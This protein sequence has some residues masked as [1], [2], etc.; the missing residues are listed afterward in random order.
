MTHST[1]EIGSITIPVTTAYITPATLSHSVRSICGRSTMMEFI[2]M[3]FQ[4]GLQGYACCDQALYTSLPLRAYENEKLKE[5]PDD[6]WDPA[7]LWGDRMWIL[8]GVAA[9]WR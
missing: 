2:R 5:E 6:F 1:P 4:K 3:C 9:P 7:C 8:P